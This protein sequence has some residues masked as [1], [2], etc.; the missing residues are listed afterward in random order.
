[1]FVVISREV[2]VNLT[3]KTLTFSVECFL[4]Q[5]VNSRNYSFMRGKST[6]SANGL[7]LE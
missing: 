3:M 6:G 4:I 5:Q 2:G 1:M 7:K